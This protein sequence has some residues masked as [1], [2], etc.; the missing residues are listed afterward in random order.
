M[1]YFRADSNSI[2][3]GGHIM[4]C[5]AIAQA[6]IENGVET[7]FLTADD[8]PI[9]VL[10]KECIPYIVLNSDWKDIMTGMDKVK[11]LLKK[12]SNALL[13]IDTYQVTKEYVEELRQ[14]GKIAYL[15]SKSGYLGEL[16]LLINYSTDINF[17]FYNNNYKNTSLLLGPSFAPLRKEFQHIIPTCKKT[18]RKI[19]VTTGNT[20]QN[21]IVSSII[22]GI[23]PIIKDK[24]IT[25]DV[26][27]GPM[28]KNNE[29]LHKA[30]D[31]CPCVVLRENVK[32]ISSIMK[33]CDLAISANGTTV[34]ELSAIGLPT[35]SFAI[36][37]EQVKSAEALHK[38]GAVD[39]CGKAFE[40]MDFCIKAIIERVS[41]YIDH[42]DEMIA[43]AERAHSLIDGNGVDKIANAII[44]MLH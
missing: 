19:L 42:I 18:I 10:D 17:S 24:S 11:E 20:D 34:Y 40:N 31:N 12:D 28:F 35:I 27:V 36:V 33:E 7:C 8:N 26:I 41:Y 38:L 30:Y 6:L 15:G 9:P 1:V 14:Y 22:N 29:H 25:L 37:E 44:E 13:L 5:L 39:Y 32:S 23:M 21:N 2:I 3:S 16:D 4:R 43:L